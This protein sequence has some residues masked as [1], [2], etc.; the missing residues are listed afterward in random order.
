MQVDNDDEQND[1]FLPFA[2]NDKEPDPPV[3]D[4][5]LSL[6][7][8]P[9]ID[10]DLPKYKPFSLGPM[11]IKWLHCHAFHFDC[12]KTTKTTRQNPIFGSCCMNGKVV[13]PI[14][15]KPPGQLAHPFS[16]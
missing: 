5:P 13:L 4:G 9:I 16:G 12:E 11:K 10:D 8:Q 1:A 14:F 15:Q 2:D 6:A 3:L 7:M